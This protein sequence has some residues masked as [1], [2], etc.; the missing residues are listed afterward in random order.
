MSW[1]K[2][3]E[4][5]RP[6]LFAVL[7]IGLAA[8]ALWFGAQNNQA[9]E[10]A[11]VAAVPS[12]T[13]A[14]TGF[15]AIPDGPTGCLDSPGGTPLNVTFNVSGLSG[16][17]NKVELNGMTFSPAHSWSADVKAIL[18]APNGASHVLF[19]RTGA[20]TSNSC[21][22]S[23]DLVGPYNFGDLNN[24]PPAGGWWQA[25]A[26]NPVAAGSYRT[27]ALGGA[28]ATNPSPATVMNSA[29]TGV[30][31]ANGTWTLRLTDHGGGDTGTLSAA[32][33]LVETAAAAP[34]KAN[35]DYDGD[36][37]T[38][39]VVARAT[40]TPLSEASAPNMGSLRQSI[41]SS[42]ETKV[43]DTRERGDNLLAPPI[44]WYT[45][46]NGSGVTAVQPFGDA[47][48]DF[49]T[50]NDYDG[51]GKTDL[52]VWRPGAATVAAFYILQSTNN[53]V[54]TD[55]FGQTGDDPAITGDYDGDGKADVATYRCPAFGAGDGQCFFFYRGSNA[56]PGGNITYQ[57]WGFGEDGDFFVNTGDFDG[58]GKHDF[59]IQRTSPIVSTPAKGQFVLLKSN[60]GGV[61]Y[62]NWGL[63][64]DFI[65]PGDYDGDGK[66]DFC[67][68]RTV[69][70]VR[71]HFILE[72]DG[73]GTPDD[74][75]NGIPWGITGDI[76]TPGDY[77]GDGKQDIAIW[78]QN[79][80]PAQNWFWVRRSSDLGTTNF[81]WGSLNDVPPASWYVH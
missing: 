21:G 11:P 45:S 41:D 50:P 49:F 60:G 51:D 68:R 8:V 56:N 16:A 80:D 26:A 32:T 63:S 14:G 48:T 38:D 33:L 73:G 70:G 4:A 42:L 62:I 9:V 18:I 57:P 75:Y 47:A 23:S 22:T 19:G 64:T 24:T 12:A 72:R 81:E 7:V 20:T 52:S 78:R 2:L 61:E 6:L 65:L 40:N 37:K 1:T 46:I 13:F 79:A 58:D 59:C 3:I 30:A 67:V 71:Q 76:S 10:K 69:S 31:N 44:Y 36:G 35:M 43:R 77:D 28:G 17:V 29:F 53:T 74:F 25:A 54:R 66:S 34:S 55:V 39:Y 5:T 27:T 15:G